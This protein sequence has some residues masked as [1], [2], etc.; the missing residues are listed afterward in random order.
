MWLLHHFILAPVPAAGPLAWPKYPGGGIGGITRLKGI[1][2]F[3]AVT[4]LGPALI[5]PIWSWVWKYMLDGRPGEGRK[6][7][8]DFKHP[9]WVGSGSSNTSMFEVRYLTSRTNL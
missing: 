7:Q 8:N 3:I 4:W 6:S 2:M 1:G 5:I 9:E